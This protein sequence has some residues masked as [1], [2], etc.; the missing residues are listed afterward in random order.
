MSK[1]PV[2]LESHEL[3]SYLDKNPSKLKD[4]ESPDDSFFNKLI[5][6]SQESFH[7]DQKNNYWGISYTEISMPYPKT[8][9][10]GK[11]FAYLLTGIE[12][13]LNIE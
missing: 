9:L 12:D 7:W 13:I 1:T 3:E 4:L 5:E 10:H 11:I 8:K 6:V 2:L